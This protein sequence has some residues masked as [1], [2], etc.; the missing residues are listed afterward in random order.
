MAVEVFIP[1]VWKVKEEFLSQKKRRI[2]KSSPCSPSPAFIR[3][4]VTVRM[5]LTLTTTI[6]V[7]I[8]SIL[9]QDTKLTSLT[10]KLHLK[11]TE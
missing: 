1:S 6:A 4:E 5:P 3:S 10:D 7:A 11:H 9:M 8:N 2:M